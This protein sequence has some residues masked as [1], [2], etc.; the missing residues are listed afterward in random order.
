[1]MKIY[2]TFDEQGLF[3]E[4]S[5]IEK[6]CWINL[7]APTEQE[8][9]TISEAVKISDEF[10]RYP[11][12]QEERA[13]IDYDDD[14]D[15]LLIVEDVP[16]DE[17]PD[18]LDDEEFSTI[19][20]GMIV[21]KD[22]FFITVCRRENKIIKDFEACKIK[23]VYTFKK[24]RFILQI[25]YRTATSYLSHLKLI[26]R[27][28]DRTVDKL[29][30]SMRNEELIKLLALQKSLVYFTTS[31]KA[32][33]IVMEKILRGHIIK[34][35]DED[36]DILEDAIVENKQAIEMGTIYRDILSGTMDAYASVISNNLNIVMKFLAGITIIFAIP[37]AIAGLWGMNIAVPFENDPNA[38][39][40]VCGITG[41]ITLVAYIIMRKKDMM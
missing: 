30:L 35:Y 2:K 23:G 6:G 3:R 36:E 27:D 7:V 4:V 28:T 9:N 38:F 25:M 11:L 32:N 18:D 22:D 10:I 8:I 5:N 39:W 13:R 41:I 17:T 21:V 1:M 15:L 34:M 20:L 37:A 24:T 16:I 40:I 31:L 12:D 29:Q 19:P 26:N 14:N 33:E